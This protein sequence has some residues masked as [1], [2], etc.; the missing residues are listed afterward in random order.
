M[1]AMGIILALMERTNSKRG[2]VVN[3]DMVRVTSIRV[4]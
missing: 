2:Q 1:C 4:G 3:A